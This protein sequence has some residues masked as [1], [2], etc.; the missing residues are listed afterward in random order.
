M[1]SSPISTLELDGRE[2]LVKRDDLIDPFLSGNK[3]RKLYKLLQTSKEKYSKIISYGGTQSNAMLAI[4]ALCKSKNWQFVYYTKPLSKRQKEQQVGNYFDALN[5]GMEHIELENELYRDFVASLR[6]NVEEKTLVVDQ[7]GADRMALEG[8]EVLAQEIRESH[9]DID[10]IATPSGTG[11]TAL[12]LAHALPEYTIYTT[13]SI[14]DSHY[15]QEQMRALETIPSNLVILE[16]KQKYHF[17]KPYKEFFA[18]YKKL[19]DK[20][21]EFDLLYAPALWINL[22]EQS[23]DRV[24]YLHSGG[25]SGNASMLQRYKSKNLI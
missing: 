11:T 16:S 9:L 14:G 12:Y 22:L 19:L 15:L 8:L 1:H 2:F 23:N 17:A 3:Y 25:V 20:G 5:L 7:G 6:M 13:P 24:L 4:A 21:I 10:A 18:M